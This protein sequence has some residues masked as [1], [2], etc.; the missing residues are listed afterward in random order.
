V[1][2]AAALTRPFFLVVLPVFFLFAAF[3]FR[4]SKQGLRGGMRPVA[5]LAGAALTPVFIWS[6]LVYA[7]TGTFAPTSLTGFNLTQHSG[8]FM[9]HADPDYSPLPEIYLRHR[10]QV[11]AESGAHS[12]TIWSAYPEMLD[13]TGL[14]FAQL[15]RRLTEMSIDLFARY[16][17]LYAQ[18]AWQGWKRFWSPTLYWMP[19]QLIYSVTQAPLNQLWKLQELALHNASLLFLLLIPTGAVWLRQRPGE[20]WLAVAVI[21]AASIG[22]AMTELGENARYAAPFQPL[23]LMVVIVWSGALVSRAAKAGA[24][25]TASRSRKNE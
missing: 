13:A 22:Q 10:A 20:E 14:T 5:L 8:A 2:S 12:M 18:T 4:K 25:M 15:S 24:R 21:S 3:R 1:L 19:D 16:P 11:L 7:V 17:S 23:L 6:A 9:E